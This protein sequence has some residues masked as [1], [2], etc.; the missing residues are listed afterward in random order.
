MAIIQTAGVSAMSESSNPY[1]SRGPVRSQEMFFGRTLEL[2]EIANF[3]RGNQ[4]VSIVGPRKVGKTSLLFHLMRPHVYEELGIPGGTLICYLDCEVFGGES[5]AEVFQQFAAELRGEIESRGLPE[6]PALESACREP[7]RLAFEAALRAL[8]RRGLPVVIILDEFERLSAN[9]NLDVHFFNALRSIAGRFQLAFV[10]ASASPLIDLTYSGKSQEILSSPFFNIFAPIFLGLLPEPDARDLIFQP[11]ELAG[12][13]FPLEIQN[14]LYEYSG[15][16]PLILQV[17][18]FH[19]FTLSVFRDE[20]EKRTA[21]EMQAH[22]EYSWRNLSEEQQRILLDIPKGTA[23]IPATPASGGVL[24]DLES[25]CLIRRTNGG[26]AY[27]SKAW[28]DFLAQRSSPP[29]TGASPAKNIIGCLLGQ[30][31]V[32]EPIGKGGMAEIY[33]ARHVRLDRAVAIKILSPRLAEEGD[34]RERFEREARAVAQLKHPNIVQV[35]DFGDCDGVY[36]MAMEYIPG[37]DLAHRMNQSRKLPLAQVWWVTNDLAAALDY[38]HERGIVHRDVKPSNVLLEPIAKAAKAG[39]RLQRAILSDFGIAKILESG[40]SST[41]GGLFGTVE[42][43]SPEQIRGEAEIDGRADVYALG[44][45]VFEMLTGRLPFQADQPSAMV[46][47][48]LNTAPPDAREFAPE[49]PENVALAIRR[50]MAKP[51][52]ER[53]PTAKDFIRA[54]R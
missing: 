45:L 26:Y 9:P 28:A 42:Y 21:Q 20:I 12:K 3:L 32:L 33:K 18:C 11:S 38:A 1:L 23:A 15:G 24:R 7:S 49:L 6:E 52:E 14:F 13:P 27:T 44:V 51:R 16:H 31:E 40:E 36:Y 54:M 19:A 41:R 2:R 50:A 46:W 17:A 30:Y 39:A 4:S 29:V 37:R 34:F 5:A 25:K 8:N 43:I 35:Y 47:A 53:F 10:T 22:F 48:H